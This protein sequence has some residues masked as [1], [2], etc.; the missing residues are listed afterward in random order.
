MLEDQSARYD[1]FS[2][3]TTGRHP[4]FN[5]NKICD[6]FHHD[7]EYIKKRTN[8]AFIKLFKLALNKFRQ[9]FR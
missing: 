2:S 3:V 6:T 5:F 4:Y 7:N 9:C 8:F 1:S